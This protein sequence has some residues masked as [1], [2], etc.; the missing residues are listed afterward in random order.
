MT[1][2]KVLPILGATLLA[3]TAILLG[4]KLLT[5]PPAIALP[6]TP[7]VSD[8]NLRDKEI[9]AR[10]PSLPSVRP[11]IYYDAIL[12]R[13]LF[14][15]TRAPIRA[16]PEPAQPTPVAATP[17]APAMDT[18]P[19]TDLILSGIMGDEDNRSALLG[20]DETNKEW[21][22]IDDELKGWTIAEIGA[23]WVELSL[24]RQ[25]YRL[26]LFE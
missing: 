17:M 11:E 6:E 26:E 10:R 19:P 24:D 18:A 23:D 3:M 12:D 25:T 14:A 21:M 7:S 8:P 1:A 5:P 22:R 20:F 15:P 9:S 2:G 4:Q 16:E 13:P